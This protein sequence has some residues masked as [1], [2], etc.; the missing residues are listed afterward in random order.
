[1]V[2]KRRGGGG[3]GQALVDVIAWCRGGV[4][5]HDGCDLTCRSGDVGSGMVVVMERDVAERW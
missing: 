1:M 4:V 5:P 2:V 3:R